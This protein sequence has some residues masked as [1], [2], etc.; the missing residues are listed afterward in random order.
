MSSASP[1]SPLPAGSY[2]CVPLPK[3]KA[4]TVGGQEL[5]GV[6]SVDMMGPANPR[7]AARPAPRRSHSHMPPHLLLPLLP[8]L[9][10]ITPRQVRCRQAGPPKEVLEVGTEPIPA[11]L[12]WGEVLLSV[13]Y[14]PINPA[15]L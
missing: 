10:P 4:Y 11:A 3:I 2:D 9:P 15:D 7:K 12:E 13:R 6:I 14:A 5:G 8:S 1:H